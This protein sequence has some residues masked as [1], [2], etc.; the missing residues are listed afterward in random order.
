MTDTPEVHTLVEGDEVKDKSPE[1]DLAGAESDPAHRQD[2]PPSK[3]VLADVPD[4]GWRAWLVVSGASCTL[5][6]SFG[7]INAF[8][9]FQDYYNSTRLP[10]ETDSVVA[11]IGAIQLFS[12]YG[13]AP[14][15]GKIFDAHGPKV[16]MPL[17][18]FCIVFSI[19]MLSLAKVN[20][21]YQYFLAQAVLF[22]IGSAMV[23]TPALAIVGHYF[24]SKRAYALG[25][26]AAGSSLGGVIFPIVLQRLLPRLGFGWSIRIMGFIALACLTFSCVTMRPRLP[27]RQAS[28]GQILRF[29]D[30]GG[31]RDP[32]YCLATA[33]AFFTFYALFIPYFYIKQFAELH[34]MSPQLAQYLL[35]IINAAGVPSRII[36]GI[37][38]DKVGVLN[39]MVPLTLGSG[40][41]SL[42]LWLPS[43]GNVPL[44]LFAVFYGLLSGSFVS[45]LP[46]FVARIS[47][48]PLFGAR[49]GAVYA[50]VAVA[51]LVG[52]PTGG[53]ITQAGTKAA[54][55]NLAAFAG[56]MVTVGGLC[57]LGAWLIEARKEKR[58]RQE[59]GG[60]LTLFLRI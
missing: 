53:G 16:L 23:F 7:I 8:G 55:R 32:S 34:G 28:L 5:F 19:M 21:T 60:S 25:I 22:G 41:L 56:T 36:P 39:M 2:S 33:S 40:I 18:S 58:L 52:T 44:I 15:I 51:N 11:L 46:A 54:Y 38:A 31:F 43:T 27:P 3:P 6:A 30:L 14:L 37:L 57:A 49:L 47:P 26:V 29:I 20:Q 35:P 4:G 13:L 48:Q 1:C 12:L 24:R 10:N 42:A 17:G 45:L 50:F 59:R 9:V